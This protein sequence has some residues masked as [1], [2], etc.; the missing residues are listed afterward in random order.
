M[1]NYNSREGA[2][3]PAPKRP[4][5]Q[6][7]RNHNQDQQRQ[8]RE[9]QQLVA[10]G[11]E[12][13]NRP[14]NVEESTTAVDEIR[15]KIEAAVNV[16]IAEVQAEV[17]SKLG[18]DSKEPL[19]VNY[20]M[21]RLKSVVR[22]S[23]TIF[24]GTHILDLP[25]LV[26]W[27]IVGYLPPE[28]V[29][30][31]RR[32]CFR[33][34]D[35][36]RTVH[37]CERVNFTTHVSKKKS[38]KRAAWTV[39]GDE[40]VTPCMDF[41]LDVRVKTGNTVGVYFWPKKKL[42]A[43]AKSI[44]IEIKCD[45]RKETLKQRICIET[46]QLSSH[47]CGW[48]VTFATNP[49]P[50]N[51]V[52][53]DVTFND[54]YDHRNGPTHRLHVEPSSC[55]GCDTNLVGAAAASASVS[56]PAPSA[57]P[58]GG[59]SSSGNGGGGG[60]GGA[61]TIGSPSLVASSGGSASFV[62]FPAA[63]APAPPTTSYRNSTDFKGLTLTSMH[64]TAP[65][66][67]APAPPS[68]PSCPPPA[69]T[70]HPSDSNATPSSSSPSS[71]TAPAPPP[72]TTTTTTTTA[73]TII[74]SAS[75]ATMSNFSSNSNSDSEGKSRSNSSSNGSSSSNGGCHGNGNS[76]CS[77][78]S[79]TNANCL[80]VENVAV[81]ASVGV[82]IPPP[83]DANLVALV[84]PPGPGIPPPNIPPPPPDEV[85]F[86]SE[87][88]PP[89]PLNA[90]PAPPAYI[91]P[92]PP[93]IIAPAPSKTSASAPAQHTHT[94][95]LANSTASATP[96]NDVSTTYTAA[97]AAITATAV[98]TAAAT[99]TAMANAQPNSS[100]TSS[101]SGLS[102]SCENLNSS[103]DESKLSIV[104]ED[105]VVKMGT[106]EALVARLT[107]EK[108]PD[109][110]FMLR[111]LLTHNAHTSPFRLLELLVNRYNLQPPPT[112]TAEEREVFM[113]TTLKS[114]RLRIFVVL[115]TWIE[116]LWNSSTDPELVEKA[117]EFAT[118]ASQSMKM[119]AEQ[120]H[121]TIHKAVSGEEKTLRIVW[122][123]PPPQPL[124]PLALNLG[125][126]LT[127][128]IMSFQSMPI[129]EIAR[130]LTLIEQ[131]IYRAIR[132]W[133]LLGLAWTKK[134][135]SLAPNVSRMIQHFNKI[136]NWMYTEVTAVDDLQMRIRTLERCIELAD[137]L[138]ELQNFNALMEVV[139]GLTN[140]CVFR[141]KK[142]WAGI[143]PL[144][145][146]MWESIR[147]LTD[148]AKNNQVLRNRI[149]SL[150]P[151]C[152]PYLGIYLTDFTFIE[153]GNQTFIE[154]K[155]NFFKCTLQAGVII[156]VQNY[157]QQPYCLD[158]VQPIADW[159]LTRGTSA[160]EDMC[161][162]RS[163]VLEPKEKSPEES[164]PT[165]V[166]EDGPPPEEELSLL[167]LFPY[168]LEPTLVKLS[169]SMTV[170]AACR[171]VYDKWK[172]KKP[173]AIST[174][175]F[176]K[177]IS[178]CD[179][180]MLKLVFPQPHDQAFMLE[181]HQNLGDLASS[182]LSN[183]LSRKG[184]EVFAL[185]P[186]PEVISCVFVTST[187]CESSHPLID[188]NA[189][190]ALMV[191]LLQIAFGTTENVILAYYENESLVQWVNCNLSFNEQGLGKGTL[192]IIALSTF[193]KDFVQSD[194]EIRARGQSFNAGEWSLSGLLRISSSI[195]SSIKAAHL[196]LQ[197][198][199][200]KPFAKEKG[201][202]TVMVDGLLVYYAGMEDPEPKHVL[203]IQ[204][205]DV[206][207]IRDSS[208]LCILMRPILPI[209]DYKPFI[210]SA[211]QEELTR[212]CF[213][214]MHTHSRVNEKTRQFGISLSVIAARPGNKSLVPSVLRDILNWLHSHGVNNN[215]LFSGEANGF[216]I[217]RFKSQFDSGLEVDLGSCDSLILGELVCVF[218]SELPEPLLTYGLHPKFLRIAEQLVRDPTNQTEIFNLS[219]LMG[220][221]PLP[222]YAVITFLIGYL[223]SWLAES[224]ADL[225]KVAQNFGPLFLRPSDA[226]AHESLGSSTALTAVMI[227]CQ[228]QI[229]SRYDKD[230]WPQFHEQFGES[231]KAPPTDIHLIRTETK[232]EMLYAI[233]EAKTL[234]G[235][236]PRKP[237]S[238]SFFASYRFPF[239]RFMLAPTIAILT[240]PT[241]SPQIVS[242]G[243][244]SAHIPGTVHTDPSY[245]TASNLDLHINTGH[246][247]PAAELLVAV[248][249]HQ[250]PPGAPRA[251]HNPPQR[252][253]RRRRD[254]AAAAAHAPPPARLGVPRHV[255]AA[256]RPR[257]PPAA[258][259]P[260]AAAPALAGPHPPDPA[261]PRDAPLAA[262]APRAPA[263]ARAAAPAGLDVA[264]QP[265]PQGR[266][267]RRSGGRHYHQYYYHLWDC[268]CK[269]STAPTQSFT[270]GR[271]A[272]ATPQPHF[273][274]ILLTA[275]NSL[276]LG[277]DT[278]CHVNQPVLYS[279]KSHYGPFFTN[280]DRL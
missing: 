113:T 51:V 133:E 252:H 101:Q 148:G 36:V 183:S 31:I 181:E 211:P 19:R 17:L 163:L 245:L 147:E 142:T 44:D 26:L 137:A 119:A 58:G 254:P 67:A 226:D 236:I 222:H 126:E 61:A 209:K 56:V 131:A 192:V 93:E 73:T 217:E 213:S 96:G 106:V 78:G 185:I 275:L 141:L 143:S 220:Q 55:G 265:R 108:K 269:T 52:L 197:A 231:Y 74:T 206:Q 1:G 23:I 273:L 221:L 201:R 35:A 235:E 270:P 11:S 153:E 176:S 173:P 4:R 54:S 46:H 237:Y 186:S 160:T 94:N 191:P 242:P 114:I 85:P 65:A 249:R 161:Y 202:W 128:E 140:S 110:Q 33:F 139:S 5:T 27:Q 244:S 232:K 48:G 64:R 40:I 134:D 117:K 225:Q 261:V 12:N 120:L 257:Q 59:G 3:E 230:L 214:L 112:C 45:N 215:R 95:N 195:H 79:T 171:L 229:L 20:S 169:G 238:E 179:L 145:N 100:L 104:L 130:Q 111:F 166:T 42:Y 68:G 216:V 251:A 15:T 132:P 136:S 158:P 167:M 194:E 38:Q 72:P 146:K 208:Q 253:R 81:A 66:V 76:S 43:Q 16:A 62:R 118:E 256:A 189:P 250:P 30:A 259:A 196:D 24:R 243:H 180:S 53:I 129:K 47:S 21:D 97:T 135:K 187:S 88:P 157:Q 50:V 268:G 109:Q 218:L 80:P 170:G 255:G 63:K 99:A 90:A 154:D 228:D 278:L 207:Y 122:D 83:N 107:T 39:T 272:N 263:P 9:Q 25:D 77:S 18:E 6:P 190:L 200:R 267:R 37:G 13:A 182:L 86:L 223:R 260:R 103:F 121:R 248:T 60:G 204:H 91:P 149:K 241:R 144:H 233:K 127:P 125:Y 98:A 71:S 32:V 177:I 258:D 277:V 124:L 184:N 219:C 138:E 10:P 280:F 84:P 165:E 41:H 89:P 266:R 172:T 159:I 123:K 276:L 22:S 193:Q 8:Q 247:H 102:N 2:V 115:K 151:P 156:N 116:N 279:R 155:V 29:F 203:P 70:T 75:S 234:G 164:K 239:R 34:W 7:N 82:D 150:H 199:S 210:L 212:T 174:P 57:A 14:A 162:K 205:F 188:C 274:T 49:G 28:S 87:L 152:I 168:E 240:K 264:A 198:K 262:P 246:A 227:K 69:S 178:Q 271:G 105:G 92:P 224:K 175:F